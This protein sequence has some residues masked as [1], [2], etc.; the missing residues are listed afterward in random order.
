LTVVQFIAFGSVSCIARLARAS[1]SARARLGANGVDV[2]RILITVCV[3][4]RRR[5]GRKE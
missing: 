5:E 4:R 1:V 2:T 3:E